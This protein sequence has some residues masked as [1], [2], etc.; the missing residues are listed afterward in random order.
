M[1]CACVHYCACVVQYSGYCIPFEPKHCVSVSLFDI[2]PRIAVNSC[3]LTVRVFRW[4][5]LWELCTNAAL[6]LL[7]LFHL[8]T[9]FWNALSHPPSVMSRKPPALCVINSR[10]ELSVQGFNFTCM[11]WGLELRSHLPAPPPVPIHSR[12]KCVDMG[13][14]CLG[15]RWTLTALS[16]FLFA[17]FPPV[18]ASVIYPSAF[19]VQ[20]AG[21]ES[22]VSVWRTCF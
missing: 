1:K 14:R 13:S 4:T 15:S 5:R 16:S 6:L 7:P 8:C 21:P 20:G 17:L 10:E 11:C 19:P 12:H 2:H 9:G 18:Q 22:P 3:F